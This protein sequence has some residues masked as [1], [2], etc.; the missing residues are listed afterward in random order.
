MNILKTKSLSSRFLLLSLFLGIVVVS[1]VG[2]AIRDSLN[3]TSHAV[4]LENKQINILNKA[5]ELKLTV[6][7]VQQWLT[8]ISATRGLDGLNDGF[9][10][11]EKN[12]ELFKKLIADLQTLDPI[13]AKDYKDMLPVFENYYAAG[14]T[15]AKAYV[16]EGPS[17]GNKMMSNF[18]GAAA[19]MS[20]KVD[21][22]L[23]KTIEL[24][25]ISLNQQQELASSSR[26][27]ILIG[28]VIAIIG[29]VFVYI[30][31]SKALSILP[32]IVNEFSKIANGDLTSELK[33]ERNDEIGDLIHGLRNMQDQLKIMISHIS[34]T[35]HQLTSLTGQMNTMATVAGEN[36]ERQQQETSQVTLAI[37]ELNTVSQDVSRNITE[38]TNATSKVRSENIKC[39]KTVN[40]AIE[41][42]HTLSKRLDDATNT[43]DE[44]AKNSNEIS[45]VLDVIQGI[46]EQTNL[47]ALNAA[48]EAARAGEQGRGFAVVADEVRSLATRTQES[49]EQIKEMIDRLQSGSKRGVEVM[50]QSREFA[51]VAVNRATEAGSSLSDISKHIVLIDDKNV[52]VASAS[53]EQSTVS[54]N[55]NQK[56]VHVNEM[57]EI[58]LKSVQEAI[59]T[60]QEIT[61][62]TRTLD[63]LVGNFKV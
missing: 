5:H 31:M 9:D 13:N 23:A 42:M 1:V 27:T 40:D 41:T 49:T 53:E 45:T 57:A 2:M 35:T 50:S 8:D 44:V 55:V 25:N 61:N 54:E 22:F 32:V 12:A 60:N 37:N 47:L 52:Q 24:T 7:Q 10:E 15:M 6:V 18:D 20:E 43:I 14:K 36:I 39:E 28:S 63:E 38:S 16:D 48:I 17:G 58:N 19:N 46:A 34:Q 62:I 59:Q 21:T 11:A 30:I 33:T 51:E 26:I 3:I 29:V 4:E 56:I